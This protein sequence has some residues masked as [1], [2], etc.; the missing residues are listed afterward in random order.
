M[1][2]NIFIL[3]S[4]TFPKKKISK[5][6]MFYFCTPSVCCSHT[7]KCVFLRLCAHQDLNVCWSDL[8]VW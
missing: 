7:I 4:L 1:T 8:S 2:L 3:D 6:C 5:N